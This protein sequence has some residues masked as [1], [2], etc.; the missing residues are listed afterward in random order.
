MFGKK[1]MGIFR[2]IFVI[3]ENGKIECII[4]KVIVKDYVV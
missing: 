4:S 2:I 1:Y 3:D